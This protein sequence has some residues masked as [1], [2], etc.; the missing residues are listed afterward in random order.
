MVEVVSGWVGWKCQK[1]QTGKRNWKVNRS[2]ED[3][4][5]IANSWSIK[6]S[7]YL[8]NNRSR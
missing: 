6:T 8:T 2:V 7:V 1:K 3:S 4:D 5:F